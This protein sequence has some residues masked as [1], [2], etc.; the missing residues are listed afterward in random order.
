MS[1]IA[2]TQMVLH[3]VNLPR[4]LCDHMLGE[5]HSTKHRMLVGTMVMVCGVMIAKL[6]SHATYEIFEIVGDLTGYLV[7]GVGAVPY[8]DALVVAVRRSS[9]PE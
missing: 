3:N 9:E 6:T 5:H 8:V 1:K 4:V 2:V 7:H